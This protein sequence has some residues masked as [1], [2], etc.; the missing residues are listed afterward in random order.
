M[1]LCCDL[2]G[3]I[4]D[5]SVY[6]PETKEFIFQQRLPNDKCEDFYDSMDRFLSSYTEMTGADKQITNATFGIAGPTDHSRVRVTNIEGWEVN[7]QT[8][9]VILEDHGHRPNSSIINDFEA[10]GYG[11][12]YMIENGFSRDDFAEIHGR[13]KLGPAR[14]G[15]ARG[16]RSLICGPGTGLGV[17]CV[18]DG[19]SKD[20]YPYIISSEGGHHSLSP[21]NP[22][23]YRFVGRAEKLTGKLS[24]EDVLSR[25]G[26]RNL[27]NFFRREDYSA[28]PNYTITAEDITTLFENGNDQAATDAVELF[29]EFL[30][31]FCGNTAL[32][33]NADKAVF[34]W[35]GVLLNLPEELVQ[36][37]FK[38]CYADRCNHSERIARVPVIL[39]K[40]PNIPLYGCAFRS[41]IEMEQQKAVKVQ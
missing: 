21:E 28:E 27:Y 23:Q 36:G 26:L 38:R 14:T 3:T 5:W 7:T 11:L 37:R 12:L 13:I 6:N 33:F 20:G 1:Y 32:T 24:Y 10:L 17:A 31:N 9:D 29:C 8:T 16:S 40:N 22:M 30:A 19:L 25:H 2:G 41:S 15:E 34:L 4:G 35:G 18:V 39:L